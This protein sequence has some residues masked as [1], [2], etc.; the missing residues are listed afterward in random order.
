MF[1]FIM[2]VIFAICGVVAFIV[3]DVEY[4]KDDGGTGVIHSRL[5]FGLPLAGL[6]GI[7]LVLS[8]LYRQSDGDVVVIKGLGGAVVGVDTTSGGG[9]TWPW[10]STTSFDITNQ[11]IEMFSNSGGDGDDGAA[12]SSPVKEG[13][14]V[15]VS[16]TV[17]FSQRSECIEEIVR[18]YRTES[19]MRERALRPGL[20]SE[21]RKATAEFSAF[22]IKQRRGELETNIAEALNERWD[23]DICAEVES[24]DLGDLELDETTEAALSRVTERQAGVQEAQADLEAA[25]VERQ[26]SNTRALAAAEQDQITRCGASTEIVTEEVAGV[27]TQVVQITPVPLSRCGNLLNDQV[28]LNNYIEALREIGSDGNLVVVDSDVQSILNIARNG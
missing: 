1:L 2:G 15:D 5:W 9:F 26:T 7:C 19:G 10:N 28:I 3:G 27:E 20:R 4:E 18:N 22:E 16:V 8:G 12:I 11:K 17:G 24:I 25:N 13:T 21:V 14:N 6:A 23:E